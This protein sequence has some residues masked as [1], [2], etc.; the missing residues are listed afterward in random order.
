MFRLGHQLNDNSER[1][2]REE[3]AAKTRSAS[4]TALCHRRQ[5]SVHGSPINATLA[6][7]VR[8]EAAAA[9]A[10]ARRS[11]ASLRHAADSAGTLALNPIISSTST[12]DRTW[13]SADT[14]APRRFFPSHG[15]RSPLMPLCFFGRFVRPANLAVENGCN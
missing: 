3:S 11:S 9:A 15:A 10:A 13:W 8:S 5:S 14:T 1:T 2:H 6:C 12:N 4:P 7:A